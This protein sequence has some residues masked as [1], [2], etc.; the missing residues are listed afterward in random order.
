V[1]DQSSPS[2]F[3]HALGFDWI[4]S[5]LGVKDL[6]GVDAFLWDSTV[7]FFGVAFF[8]LISGV[9]PHF[10][11]EFNSLDKGIGKSS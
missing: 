8:A 5:R 10:R 3:V 9:F 7:F 4:L 2:P 11:L 6:F 1:V